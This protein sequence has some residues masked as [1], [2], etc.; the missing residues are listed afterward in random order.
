MK[1]LLKPGGILI[2]IDLEMAV[3]MRDGSDPWRS[4]PTI[5]SY[6]ERV[7]NSLQ[8][9]GIELAYMPLIGTW[10][11]E[12][13]GFS[14]VEDTVTSIPVG[15]WDDDEIQ[16]EIGTMARDNI[17]SALY[18]T[19]PLWLRAGKS[20]EEV[21]EIVAKAR[22]ELYN[23]NA[24]LFERVFYVFARKEEVPYVEDY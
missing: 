15:P 1:R 16:R 4:V 9:Q 19:H 11:R 21:E 5:C 13:G 20:L 24:E 2:T 8:E 6:T 17:M 23:P 3:W 7:H 18:S 12:M 14:E 22:A 10:L